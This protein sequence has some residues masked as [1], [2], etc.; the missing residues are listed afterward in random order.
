MTR[1]LCLVCPLLFFEVKACHIQCTCQYT[2]CKTSANQAQKLYATMSFRTLSLTNRQTEPAAQSWQKARITSTSLLS[3]IVSRKLEIRQCSAVPA[4]RGN[5][6]TSRSLTE[7][8][9]CTFRGRSL[10]GTANARQNR[11]VNSVPSGRS[12][13]KYKPAFLIYDHV[14]IGNNLLNLQ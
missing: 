8:D 6:P 14:G 9:R 11:Y 13:P 5:S 10:S 4:F 7:T 1:L 2:F 3:A 12:G